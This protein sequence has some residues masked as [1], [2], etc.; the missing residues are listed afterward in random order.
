MPL[1]FKESKLIE[2]RK[3]QLYS[4][5]TSIYIHLKVFHLVAHFGFT[6]GSFGSYYEKSNN[7][8]Q[9]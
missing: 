8:T 5:R 7:K 3:I 2:T 1:L 6:I 9:R 4:Y